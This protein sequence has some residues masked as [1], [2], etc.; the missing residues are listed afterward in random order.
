MVT[1]LLSLS[2]IDVSDC[3]LYAIRDNQPRLVL[4]ILEKLHNVAPGLEFA[5]AMHSSEFPE[6]ITPVILAAQVCKN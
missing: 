6:Y 2:N 4:L 1:Y 3:I 5:G